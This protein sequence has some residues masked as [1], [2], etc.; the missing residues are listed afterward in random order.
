M[1]ASKHVLLI[2]VL[3]F[4]AV[5]PGTT[6]AQEPPPHD[7]PLGDRIFPPELV[8]RHQQAIG[9]QPDQKQALRDAISQ[10]QVR[11]TELQWDLED[12]SEQLYGR[13]APAQ[14]DPEQVLEALDRVLDAE[15]Q[16]KRA[17]ISLMVRIKHLL[18]PEQQQRLRELMH[19]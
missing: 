7:D 5:G 13:L 11:F 6:T 16:I 3:V 14:P 1:R 10:A 8:M 17:Q 19:R 18:T 15:R 9:L 12:A 4:A 2:A